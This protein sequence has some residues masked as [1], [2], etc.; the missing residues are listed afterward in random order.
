GIGSMLAGGCSAVLQSMNLANA[1]QAPAPN[2]LLAGPGKTMWVTT[3]QR[4]KTKIYQN[5]SLSTQPLLIVV[6]DGDSS[7]RPPT[8]QY[9]FAE[10]AAASITDAVVA[11]VLRPGYGDGEDRS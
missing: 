5:A 6:L 10:T 3:T 1:Q 2:G 9:R 8:Y 4:L 7:D 11:A